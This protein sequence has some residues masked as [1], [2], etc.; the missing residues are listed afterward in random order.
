V[1]DE[2][3]HRPEAYPNAS[4][5]PLISRGVSNARGQGYCGIRSGRRKK[6]A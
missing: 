5:Y 6:S 3:A 1:A 2:V 4:S